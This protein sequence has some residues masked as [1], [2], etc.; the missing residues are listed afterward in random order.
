VS[1]PIAYVLAKKKRSRLSRHLQ[2]SRIIILLIVLCTLFMVAACRPSTSNTN[3]TPTTVPEIIATAWTANLI[4]KLEM[5]DGC[6]HVISR[7]DETDYVLVWPPD[8]SITIENNK[9]RVVSG[10]VTGNHKE[11]LL[12]IGETVKMS[13]GETEQL[14]EKM[15][16]SLPLNCTGPYWIVGFEVAP[17][18]STNR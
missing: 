4:G 1:H 9:V 15:L 12:N 13:G 5:T 17:F 2:F 10:N 7:E 16:Q 6:L 14:S 8:F 18:E 3:F 11:V